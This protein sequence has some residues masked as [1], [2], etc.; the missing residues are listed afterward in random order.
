MWEFEHLYRALFG[1]DDVV[2]ERLRRDF[3]IALGRHCAA[4][5]IGNGLACDRE[6]PP[7]RLQRLADYAA[8]SYQFVIIA[9]ETISNAIAEYDAAET[10]ETEESNDAAAW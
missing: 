8:E 9:A 6:T 7:D 3:L 5:M 4:R 10:L 2:P 1:R